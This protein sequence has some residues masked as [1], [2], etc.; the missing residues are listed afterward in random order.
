MRGLL[1]LSAVSAYPVQ[2]LTRRQLAQ[3]ET[4]LVGFQQ[5]RLD[6]E[7]HREQ[8]SKKSRYNLVQ[9]LHVKRLH[10]LCFLMGESKASGLKMPASRALQPIESPF[11]GILGAGSGEENLDATR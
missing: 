6:W 4:G 3:H 9:N 2:L 8:P 10:N 7:A 1:S 11:S 5:V